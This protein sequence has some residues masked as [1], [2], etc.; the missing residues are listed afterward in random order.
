MYGYAYCV[1]VCV[2]VCVC[3]LRAS[4]LCTLPSASVLPREKLPR[5][6]ERIVMKVFPSEAYLR[7]PSIRP[8]V[9]RL[10]VLGE[11]T[12]DIVQCVVCD[13]R[14]ALQHPLEYLWIQLGRG[15]S[16][17]LDLLGGVEGGGGWAEAR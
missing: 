13:V 5:V 12:H 1:C 6:V 3:E 17:F 11:A 4:P 2:C 9:T 8:Y 15:A 7:H 16:C 14:P 10:G